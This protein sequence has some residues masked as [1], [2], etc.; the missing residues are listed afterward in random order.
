[1]LKQS[2]NEDIGALYHSDRSQNSGFIHFIS[3]AKASPLSF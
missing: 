2:T 1:M 3:E